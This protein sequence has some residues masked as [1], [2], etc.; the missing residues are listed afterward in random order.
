MDFRIQLI[1]VRR[2]G[3]HRT[4]KDMKRPEEQDETLIEHGPAASQCGGDAN[5]AERGRRHFQP[6]VQQWPV[7]DAAGTH[8]VELIGCGVP[9]REGEDERDPP[10]DAAQEQPE[11]ERPQPAFTGGDECVLWE[12]QMRFLDSGIMKALGL[13]EVNGFTSWGGV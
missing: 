2:R 9:G 13:R 12:V 7:F 11:S 10:S 5:A 8:E 6:V 1:D 3:E 4:H